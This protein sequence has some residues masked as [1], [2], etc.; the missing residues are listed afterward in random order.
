MQ[1]FEEPEINET[2][3][4]DY[5]ILFVVDRSGSMSGNPMNITK[6]ALQLFIQSLPCSCKYQIMSFGNNYDYLYQ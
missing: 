3:E 1:A 4:G 5:C 6:K 2:L